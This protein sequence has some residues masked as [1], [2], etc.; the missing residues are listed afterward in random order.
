MSAN[1]NE[2]TTPE[3]DTDLAS[4]ER[5]ALQA[6]IDKVKK[7]DTVENK[8]GATENTELTMEEQVEHLQ[9]EL[10]ALKDQTLRAMADSENI[11]RR[12]ERE[13]AAAKLFGIEYFAAD[14]LSVV[15]NL[16]RAISTLE[17]KARDD[18]G[19]NAKNLLE[20]I[21]LTEKN[22]MA[23][24]ARHNVKAVPGKGA[25]FDPKVHQVVAQIPSDEDKGNVAEVMQTGFT[26]SDRILRAAMVAVS[27][28][29]AK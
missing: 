17:G 16:S 15:D 24:L 23:I 28:G 12:A 26:I 19:D 5:D 25:R 20:G 9:T 3:P 18:L 6:E 2:N 21:E 11:K 7:G 1:T 14:L 4:D 27:T 22:L 29:S 10:A 8:A 13:V